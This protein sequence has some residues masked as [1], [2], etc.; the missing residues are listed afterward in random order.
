MLEKKQECEYYRKG[1]KFVFRMDG[2]DQVVGESEDHVSN[3]EN[4]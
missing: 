3:E 2:F 1:T 4:H